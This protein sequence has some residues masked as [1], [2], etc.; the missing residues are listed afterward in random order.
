[1]KFSSQKQ[2][3]LCSCNGL[4]GFHNFFLSLSLLSYNSRSLNSSLERGNY[5]PQFLIIDR[6]ANLHTFFR[7]DVILIQAKFLSRLNSRNSMYSK[8][9]TK[10]DWRRFETHSRLWFFLWKTIVDMR[11]LLL[12][13]LR[14]T[15]FFEMWDFE[16]F[17]F[18]F[19]YHHQKK[20]KIIYKV[21]SHTRRRECEQ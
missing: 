12:T 2:Q 1:M 9:R 6:N 7:V 11:F 5:S 13:S 15:F 17:D 21:L 3:K 14:I 4:H 20:M 8:W 16:S 19:S 10:Q 18:K